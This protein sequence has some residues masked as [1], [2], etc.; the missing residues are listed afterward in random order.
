MIIGAFLSFNNKKLIIHKLHEY[1]D[2]LEK[3][4]RIASCI[5]HQEKNRIIA[6]AIFPAFL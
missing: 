5:P 3:Q 4:K 2:N 6:T 1:P